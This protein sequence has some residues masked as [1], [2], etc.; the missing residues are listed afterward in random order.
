M[1]DR[2]TQ[3]LD[4]A[5]DLL[6]TRSFTAFS[7]QDLSD[8]LG[9]TKAAIHGHFRTKEKLGVAL[10]DRYKAEATMMLEAVSDANADPWDRF[11]AFVEA[12]YHDFLKDHKICPIGSLQSEFQ[13]IPESM[14]IRVGQLRRILTNFLADSLGKGRDTGIMQF[15][16][17]AEEQ[18]ELVFAT[19]QGALQNARA[20]GHQIFSTIVSQLKR[21]MQV[22]AV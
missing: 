13:V 7:Y 9:I 11:E 15:P 21:G 10:I 3:I 6:Q 19:L 20:E 12:M 14:Q 8:R 17:S 18:A 1:N 5:A 4:V 2:K 16:G 22:D